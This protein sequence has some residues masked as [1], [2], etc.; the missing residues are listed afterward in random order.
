MSDNDMVGSIDGGRNG[1]Y[2]S[3]QRDR[4]EAYLGIY[5]FQDGLLVSCRS[6]QYKAQFRLGNNLISIAYYLRDA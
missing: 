6:F 4:E 5:L 3:I 2:G 1:G